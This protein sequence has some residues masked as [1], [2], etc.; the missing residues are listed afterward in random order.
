MYKIK[1]WILI[2]DASLLRHSETNEEKRIGSHDFLVLLALCSE[3]GMVVS[4]ETILEKAWPGKIVSDSSITQAISN[5]RTLIGDNG[6]EQ[7]WL[8]TIAKVG[9]KLESEIVKDISKE[10]TC[11]DKNNDSA[12]IAS[13]IKASSSQINIEPLHIAKKKWPYFSGSLIFMI[14]FYLIGDAPYL[15]YIS[16]IKPSKSI[17]PEQV[18]SDSILKIYS[19][20]D[21]FTDSISDS[22]NNVL[23]STSNKKRPKSIYLMLKK[24]SLS[25]VIIDSN[26]LPHNMIIL[27]ENNESISEIEK[28]TIKEVGRFVS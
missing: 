8:K 20:N 6:K 7:K 10:D 26:K 21:E 28:L 11:E 12:A 17:T 27:L 25:I 14:S 5:I 15:P 1:D 16:E 4:K 24:D 19:D 3:A 22:I 2:K 18:Y 13:P 9:Y 23:I